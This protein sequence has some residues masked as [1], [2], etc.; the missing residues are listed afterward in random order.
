MI[1]MYNNSPDTL[2]PLRRSYVERY[3]DVKEGRASVN[4]KKVND[5]LKL[6]GVRVLI[7]SAISDP[8]ECC[9]AYEERNHVETAFNTLKSRL[10]CNR[11]RVNDPGCLEGMLLVEMLATAI[12]G[13]AR[14][15]IADYGRLK[16]T[17]KGC[18]AH[19]DSDVMLFD[20][21]NN[22]MLTSFKDGWY[23]DEIAGNRRELFSV[24]NVPVPD[25]QQAVSGE[26]DESDPDDGGE[27]VKETGEIT[28][29]MEL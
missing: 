27:S 15:R 6:T 18:S 17:D 5:A 7:S 24:L 1:P 20:K 10:K 3:C 12:A 21:L 19:V 8:V 9:R 25:K 22:I 13:M 16:D 28:G 4:M 26:Q 23:F 2:S 29:Q 14:S 11:N